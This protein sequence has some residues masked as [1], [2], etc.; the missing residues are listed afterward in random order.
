MTVIIVSPAIVTLK[1]ITIIIEVNGSVTREMSTRW[2]REGNVGD[3][4][5]MLFMRKSRSIA[6][7][8]EI[9]ERRDKMCIVSV[10]EIGCYVETFMKEVAGELRALCQP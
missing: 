8:L 6:P 7:I 2:E 1:V 10:H 5:M 9:E 4:C 3:I